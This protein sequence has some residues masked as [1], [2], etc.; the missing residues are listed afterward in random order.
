MMNN[1]N[2]V[3]LNLGFLPNKAAFIYIKAFIELPEISSFSSALNKIAEENGSNFH[4]VYD[5]IRRA[6]ILAANCG[7]LKNIDKYFLY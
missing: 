3:L 4:K 6:I 2:S 1:I 7:K 5:S